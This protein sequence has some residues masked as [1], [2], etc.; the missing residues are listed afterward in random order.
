MLA[1]VVLTYRAPPGMLEG[2]VASVVAAGE[3][4]LVVVVD[5]GGAVVGEALPAGVALL[6]NDG[7]CGYAGGMNAG[8][9]L[10]RRA[11]ADAVALLND[12]TTVPPGWLGGLAARL[13][14][15]VGAV[16]PKLLLGR[17]GASPPT[18]QSVGLAVRGDGAGVDV[19]YGEVDTGQYDHRDEIE[20]FT[21]AAVLLAGGFL[22]ELGGFDERYFMY[23]E[24]VDL[25]RRGRAA[26]WRY[27]LAPD[28]VV[29]HDMSTTTSAMPT[30]RRYWQERN[31]LWCLVRHGS[32]GQVA[33]GLARSAARLAKHPGGAQARAIRDGLAAAPR[34]VGERRRGVIKVAPLP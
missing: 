5:N 17:P 32:P 13:G 7:N 16:Q 10:A 11:G 14:G 33:R 34:L 21:G 22:A 25:A 12:D 29:Y 30:Q 28:V 9:A 2:C 26:G 8:M 18:L 19:G 24:D 23:Y 15:R 3:A 4:D 1:V 27:R 6:R 31:R 20:A